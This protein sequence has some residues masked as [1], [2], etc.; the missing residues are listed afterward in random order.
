MRLS[1]LMETQI[2]ETFPEECLADAATRMRDHGIGSLP[3]IDGETLVG[4]ITDRDLMRAVA[5]GSP[6]HVTA[7]ATY[8]SRVP[9]VAG[10]DDDSVT[11]AQLMVRHDVRH[12]PIVEG[13]QLVGMVSARDLLVLEGWPLPTAS[14]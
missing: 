6:P 3:V 4:I 11:A 1:E 10:P 2:V 14:R 7:V 8:M 9:V 12:L 5:E 13:T